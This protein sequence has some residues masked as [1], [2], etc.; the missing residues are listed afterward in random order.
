[1]H[2]TIHSLVKKL[3]IRSSELSTQLFRSHLI[4]CGAQAAWPFK[5]E[6]SNSIK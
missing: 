5:R 4:A 6:N 2:A 1:M 3:Y